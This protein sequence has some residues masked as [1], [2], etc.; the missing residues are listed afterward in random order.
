MK[1]LQVISLSAQ[2]SFYKKVVG[3][4]RQKLGDLESKTTL[5][6][7]VYLF[8]IG[9]NDYTSIFLTNSTIL[10][11]YSKSDYVGMVIGNLTIAIKEVYE[12]G[13][14][15]FGFL[16]LG[17]LGCLPGIRI[18]EPEING[19]CL[20]DA[21]TLAKLHNEALSKMLSELENQLKDFRYALYD[22]H[23]N[24]KERMDHP[25]K[26]GFKE[27]ITAC[28]GTGEL[29]G[30]F[31]CGGKRPVKEFELCDNPSEY[32]FWDSIHLTEEAYKQ[33][34][35]QMWAGGHSAVKPYNLKNLFQCLY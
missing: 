33:M 10:S 18:L 35:E 25:S 3:V 32:V 16:N 27:G 4:L 12:R 30:V 22:F 6:N 23:T 1:F 21:S 5:S 26:Y 2:L 19:G 14:R 34:A 7:A 11:F 15:K 29:R 24:L 31:S 13:G 17:P 20:E 28:C 8:S 9:T